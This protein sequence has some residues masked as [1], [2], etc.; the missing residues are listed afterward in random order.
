VKS[1]PPVFRLNTW[2][3]LTEV[4]SPV[5]SSSMTEMVEVERYFVEW[6]DEQCLVELCPGRI[7]PD[8]MR[9][10]VELINEHADDFRIRKGDPCEQTK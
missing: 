5:G 7:T 3:D 1:E 4:Q 2:R 10:V 8:Q 9:R 6:A